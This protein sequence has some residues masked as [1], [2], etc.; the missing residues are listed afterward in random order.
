[1]TIGGE[2]GGVTFQGSRLESS[3]YS[4]N[5]LEFVLRA[6]SVLGKDDESPGLYLHSS[7]ELLASHVPHTSVGRGLDTTLQTGRENK[8]SQIPS[9]TYTCTAWGQ[10]SMKTILQNLHAYSMPELLRK[11]FKYPPVHTHAQHG[12]L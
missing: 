12:D 6:V 8:H 5:S 7:V 9:S 4:L 3:L 2:G 1:M 10:N 11:H